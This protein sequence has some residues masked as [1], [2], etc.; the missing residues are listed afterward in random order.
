MF[1]LFFYDVI[2]IS[3][4][5]ETIIFVMKVQLSYFQNRMIIIFSI[6]L[7]QNQFCIEIYYFDRVENLA[8]DF[9]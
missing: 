7:I 4:Y 3:D 2:L 1:S 9:S 5:R 8:L 6:T